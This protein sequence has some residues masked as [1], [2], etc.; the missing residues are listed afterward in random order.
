M[1]KH[2]R[3][4]FLWGMVAGVTAIAPVLYIAM[5]AIANGRLN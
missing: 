4:I 5:L 1:T 3:E 2:E